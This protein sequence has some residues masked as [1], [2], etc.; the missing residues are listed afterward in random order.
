MQLWWS[1][2][3]IV[4]CSRAHSI[5]RKINIYDE[6]SIGSQSTV[7]KSRSV[8]R[9]AT[10]IGKRGCI[11]FRGLKRVFESSAYHEDYIENADETHFVFNI[12]NGRTSGFRAQDEVRYSDAL[13]GNEG[14][15][16][17][18]RSLGGE[19]LMLFYQRKILLPNR[20]Y[21]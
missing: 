18:V 10:S 6:P 4:T 9:K 14:I 17:T 7:W 20:W 15:S 11:L 16:M 5:S 12:D 8:S 1:L 21:S 19:M 2:R 3:F 13:S